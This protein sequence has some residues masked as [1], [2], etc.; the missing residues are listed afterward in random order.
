MSLTGFEPTRRSAATGSRPDSRTRLRVL[1]VLGV[2]PAACVALLAPKSIA[3]PAAS[4]LSL[5]LALAVGIYAW[6][7]RVNYRAQGLTFWDLAGM[8]ALVG[9]GAGA[10]S[11]PAAALEL[12]G[13]STTK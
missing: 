8:F 5:V 7:A 3:L 12:F 11:D 6:R 10:M 13:I 1:F 9:F 4:L 2:I